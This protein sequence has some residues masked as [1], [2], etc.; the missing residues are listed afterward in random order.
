MFEI[1][2]T[3]ISEAGGLIQEGWPTHSVSFLDTIHEGGKWIEPQANHIITYADDC[4][5]DVQAY[6]LDYKAPRKVQIERVLAFTADLTDADVVLIHCH[7]GVSRSTAMAIGICIQHGM[8]VADAFAHI[9]NVR[10]CLYPNSLILQY[11]DEILNLEGE[12][13]QFN[14]Q[15][16]EVKK[17]TLWIPPSAE[18]DQKETQ[19]M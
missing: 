15:W 16:Q 6:G 12:L 3:G 17:N 13:I 4:D 7:Q 11:I 5:R 8:N 18:K 19:E 2:I 14:V 10:S 1:K 9:E